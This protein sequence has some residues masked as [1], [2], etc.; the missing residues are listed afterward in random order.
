MSFCIREQKPRLLLTY[1]LTEWLY[2]RVNRSGTRAFGIIKEQ[3]TPPGFFEIFPPGCFCFNCK[4]TA[5]RH[6]VEGNTRHQAIHKVGN[7]RVV[8]KD[9]HRNKVIGKPPDYVVKHLCRGMIKGR[10]KKNVRRIAAVYLNEIRCCTLCPKCRTGN[11]GIYLF[12]LFKKSFCHFGSIFFPTVV[13]RSLKIASP[14]SLIALCMPNNNDFFQT[15][16]F[17]KN[18]KSFTKPQPRELSLRTLPVISLH[19]QPPYTPFS[20]YAVAS[21]LVCVYRIEENLTS[22]ITNKRVEADRAIRDSIQLPVPK[23]HGWRIIRNRL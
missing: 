12:F 6:I 18:K 2:R 8:R 10:N 14:E 5:S 23:Y 20:L 15:P 21:F 22:R 11:P 7:A 16:G 13:E 19:V 3:V 4:D 9:S 1:F 17:Y